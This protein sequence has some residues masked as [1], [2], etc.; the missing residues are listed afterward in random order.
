MANSLLRTARADPGIFLGGGA[1]VSCSSSTPINHKVFFLQNTSCTRKPQVISGGGGGRTPS[2]P[3]PET[4]PPR[5]I[6]NVE[7][8]K[9]GPS[10]Q[11]SPLPFACSPRAVFKKINRRPLRRLIN[12]HFQKYHYK[13]VVVCRVH[14]LHKT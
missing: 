7:N 11:A 4:P 3:P 1:L 9:L 14:F 6:E 2:P 13:K 10:L 8:G 12:I 5:Q